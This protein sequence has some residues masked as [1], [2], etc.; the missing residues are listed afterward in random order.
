LHRRIFLSEFRKDLQGRD[1]HKQHEYA[2][3]YN[4]ISRFRGWCMGR[5]LSIASKKS[6]SIIG[7]MDSCRKPEITTP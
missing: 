4:I 6:K 5:I 1:Q 2:H 7:K 3:K